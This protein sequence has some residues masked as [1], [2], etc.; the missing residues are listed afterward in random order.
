MTVSLTRDLLEAGIGVLISGC[1]V[2]FR[3][4]GLFAST[5]RN[6]VGNTVCINSEDC[7]MS[8]KML[9]VEAGACGPPAGLKLSILSTVPIAC[10]TTVSK[11]IRE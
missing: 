5:R 11:S 8:R 10:I 9:A 2:M 6:P 4:I 3:P 7:S 1:L